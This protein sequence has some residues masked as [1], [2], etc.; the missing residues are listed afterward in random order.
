MHPSV[1]ATAT[2]GSRQILTAIAE[3]GV[4]RQLSEGG[5]RM[6][7][8]VCGP[9]VGMGQAPPSDTNSLRTMN[10]NFPGRSGTPNDSV[11]LC[12]PA[13][14]AVSMI[15]GKIADPREYGDAPELLAEPELKPYVDDVHIFKPADEA[16]AAG[17]EIPRGPN[18]K[19]P[20]E[21][22]PSASS[23]QTP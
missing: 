19:K 10:R 18:I 22:Q 1:A 11:Y 13:V 9:C 17:I 3:S 6:L 4:Y 7:E 12:S 14:A 23:E 2:P 8:P 5:V 16:E 15:A 21:H 20:P